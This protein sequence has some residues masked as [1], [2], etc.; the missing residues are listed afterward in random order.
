MRIFCIIILL[1]ATTTSI[2]Q[3]LSN[4]KIDT[5]YHISLTYYQKNN[6]NQSYSGFCFVKDLNNYY[7]CIDNKDSIENTFYNNSFYSFDLDWEFRKS[8]EMFSEY[9]YYKSYYLYNMDKLS[10]CTRCDYTD[11]INCKDNATYIIF[12]IR[13]VIGLFYYENIEKRI[14]LT[15]GGLPF[16]R[17]RNDDLSY[18]YRCFVIMECQPVLKEEYLNIFKF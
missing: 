11:S 3:N 9:E 12:T 4:L 13:K 16:V 2:A 7:I 14:I 17:S 8:R 5:M 18:F 15:C 10:E 1:L 6:Q